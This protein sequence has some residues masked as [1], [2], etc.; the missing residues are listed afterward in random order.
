MRIRRILAVFLFAVLAVACAGDSASQPTSPGEP[1]HHV[2]GGGFRNPEG[3]PTWKPETFDFVRFILA[4]FAN[5][6]EHSVVPERYLVPRDAAR[7]QLAA[8]AEP[9]I[10]WIGHSTFVIAIGGHTILTDP[11]F[12]KRASPFPFAGP[13]RFVP[14]GLAIDELPPIDTI[15]ISH[16][17]YDHMD[18]AA[19]RQLAQRF[20]SA[21]VLVPLGD[22]PLMKKTG[23]ANVRELD[24]YDMDEADG[25]N[26][27][28]VPAIHR[29]NRGLFDLNKTLWSGYVLAAGGLKIWFAGDTGSGPVFNE[30]SQRVGPVDVALVP[31]GAYLPRDVLRGVHATP[32]ESVE[33]ARIMGAK[34]VIGMHWGTLPLGAD[35]PIDDIKHFDAADAEGVTK[36]LMK[37]GETRSLAPISLSA[38]PEG[39]APP[40]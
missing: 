16:N 18:L 21:R 8:T 22:G 10:T 23:F 27:T 5:V 37:I 3:S 17:H 14:P 33:L 7:A 31:I 15:V 34:T 1:Y 38:L 6:G 32:E 19:L 40:P 36:V 2:A 28:S 9:R 35:T 20:P 12:S 4:R 29:A 30:V 13:E 25:L 24:W 11:F 39:R 26:I